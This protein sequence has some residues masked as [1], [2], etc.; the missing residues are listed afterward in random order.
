MSDRVS[1]GK[2]KGLR[3]FWNRYTRILS[4]N[5]WLPTKTDYAGSDLIYSNGY[6][7]SIMSN[8]WFTARLTDIKLN[9]LYQMT[10]NY[11]KTYL[12]YAISSLQKTMD[13]E[14]KETE[15]PGRPPTVTRAQRFKLK[16]TT[17]QRKVIKEWF[18]CAR[19]SYN[20]AVELLKVRSHTLK[21]LR[22]ILV[23]NN[24]P[25]VVENPWLLNT[26]YDIRDYAVK[27]AC[28]AYKQGITRVK[29]GVIPRFN[30]KF[31]SKK[32]HTDSIFIRNRWY[33]N[34]TLTL[35]AWKTKCE[36]FNHKGSKVPEKM[37]MCGRLIRD[38][39]GDIY[40]VNTISR[41]VYATDKSSDNQAGLPSIIALDP[42]NRTFQTGYDYLGRIV[43][44]G[45]GD[46]DKLFNILQHMDTLISNTSLKCKKIHRR[47]RYLI[48]KKV[49]P[50]IR[51]RI[52]NLINDIHNRVATW[53]CENYEYIILPR[54]EVSGMVNKRGR[55]LKKYSVRSMLTWS[56][57]RFSQILKNKADEY[58]SVLHRC[59]EEYT[60]QTCPYC[61]NLRKIGGKTYH[62]YECNTTIDRDINGCRNIFLKVCTESI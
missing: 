50:R 21:E 28:N 48:R 25:K 62:C 23:N 2:E 47:Q 31:R 36:P 40:L 60:S 61:G 55:K 44:F 57:Y 15:G 3:P 34:G 27:E 59:T 52:H 30:L 49:I 58:G 18:G 19:W 24:S 51:K 39:Y 37:D 8:S 26:P 42:G 46:Q 33:K 41:S 32:L 22:S 35:N 45:I 29:N 5:L 7:K 1:T 12:R 14:L 54:F 13:D 16:T 4:K 17:T 6:S 38:K 10:L 11:H 9:Q 56:H 20:K 53:L 43:E